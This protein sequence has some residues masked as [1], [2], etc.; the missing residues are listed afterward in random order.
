MLFPPDFERQPCARVNLDDAAQLW[1]RHHGLDPEN[2][3]VNPLLDPDICRQMVNEVHRQLEVV[4]SSGG[5]LEDRRHLW[6]GQRPNGERLYLTEKERFLHMGVDF[7]APG[8]I[9]I[10][11]KVDS[12]VIH[13]SNDRDQNGGWGKHIFLRRLPEGMYGEY[14]LVIAHIRD[15]RVKVRDVIQAHTPFARVGHPPRNGNW[16]PHVHLQSILAEYF[17]R[18][19]QSGALHHFD[20]YG[21]DTPA[22]RRIARNLYPDPLPLIH[23]DRRRE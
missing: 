14:L 16:Y 21:P 11:L 10:Q 20:G 18:L 19:R 5:W 8:G 3:E 2:L 1:L 22:Y 23:P 15:I 12:E 4:W 9:P 7:N 6:G 17:F 13:I